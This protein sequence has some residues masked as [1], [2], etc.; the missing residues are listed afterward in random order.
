MLM[1]MLIDILMLSD[2][3]PEGLFI[4]DDIELEGWSIVML[5]LMLSDMY[6]DGLSISEDVEL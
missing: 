1:L 6:P 4:S 3:Y 5:M 2:M